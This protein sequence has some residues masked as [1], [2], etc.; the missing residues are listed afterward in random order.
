MATDADFIVLP[1]DLPD[2]AVDTDLDA[3]DLPPTGSEHPPVDATPPAGVLPRRRV[4][5]AAAAVALAVGSGLVGGV[6]GARTHHSSAAPLA[7]TS[8]AAGKSAGSALAPIAGGLDVKRIVA[9]VE[10]SVV[11]IVVR[12]RRGGGEGTGIVLSASGDVLT[13]AHVVSGATTVSVVTSDGRAHDA[14]VAGADTTHDVALVRV[15]GVTLTPADLGKSSD[16]AVGDDVVAVGNALGLDGDPTVT[17]GIVSG[18]NRTLGDLNGLIQTDA[19]INP[20]NSGGPLVDSAGQVIGMNTAIATGDNAQNIGF[21]IPIDSARSIVQR[22]ASGQTAP[23]DGFLGV[24]T[25]APT[26][27]SQGA[28]VA[29]VVAGGPAEAAGIAVGDVITAVDG[30]AVTSSDALVTMIRGHA[31]GDTV[32]LSVVNGDRTR[33]VKVKLGTRPTGTG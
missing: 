2:H 18:L 32:T 23:A 5:T 17:R 7:S 10:P 1:P 33:T 19:A 3:R 30:S 28:L 24:S 26:D 22:L 29:D 13:N 16:A 21:A 4:G 20:G 9:K 6:V 27:G 8:V 14:S 11:R 12:T 15:S 31:P 25:T